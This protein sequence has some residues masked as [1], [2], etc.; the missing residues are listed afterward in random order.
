M[1]RNFDPLLTDLLRRWH[2]WA[3]SPVRPLDTLLQDF[4]ALVA[5][6]SPR[7]R[8]AIV[9]LAA[10]AQRNTACGAAVW[11]SPRVD[12]DTAR[13]ARARLLALLLLDDESRWFGRRTV[14]LN[15]RGNRIGESNPQ[16]EV[17]DHDVSL[18]LQLREEGYSLG[19]LARKFEVSRS[20]V[21]DWCNGRRRGQM[22]AR[23]KEV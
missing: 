1:D 17:S 6:L 19:W 4:D 2:L 13:R 3:S 5:K 20:T 23:V 15:E 8:G 21:Q 7:Q 14:V 10:T 11:S 22:P 9:A 16:A 18:C 12:R